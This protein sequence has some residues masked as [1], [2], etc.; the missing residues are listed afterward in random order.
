[1]A[2]ANNHGVKI[3]YEIEGNGQPIVLQY[4]QYF[5]L[6]VWREYNYV[7][8]L[9]DNFQLILV[10]ARGHG[11]SDKPE[12]A[13]AYQLESMV[14]DIITVL[15]NLRLQQAIYMG[16][17]SGGGVGFGLARFAPE[18]VSAL[19]IGGTSPYCTAEDRADQTLWAN[20]QIQSLQNQTAEDFVIDL[21]QYISSI[22]LPSLSPQMHAA[23]LK[24]NPKALIAWLRAS[25]DWPSFENNLSRMTM[26]CLL[27]CGEHDSPEEVQRASEEIPNAKFVCI[28]GGEHL[29]GG[30]WIKILHS[31]ILTLASRLSSAY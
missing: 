7:D 30:T 11:D 8:A 9:K 24:H 12:G 14:N 23:L 1:M 21:E 25:K 20:E 28:P 19:I 31:E 13:E 15:D 4:G 5:P 18:R 16:Y 27:Y 22:S 2:Y 29:E 6:Q 26:P 3:Y 17:S 10:D